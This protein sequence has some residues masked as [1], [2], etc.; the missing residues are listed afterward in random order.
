MLIRTDLR[1]RAGRPDGVGVSRPPRRSTA[2]DRGTCLVGLLVLVVTLA[3]PDPVAPWS[4]WL[5]VPAVVAAGRRPLVLPT[6]RSHSLVIGLDSTLLVLLGLTLPTRQALVV[7]AVAVL[8]GE[9]TTRRGLQT[10]LFNAGVCTL[11]GLVALAL[12]AV[13]PAAQRMH[14]LGLVVTVL[15]SA[16]Y[17]VVDYL[18]SGVSVAVAQRSTLRQ[19]LRTAGLPLALACFLGVNSLGFLAAVL[20]T[21]RPWTVGLLALPFASLQLSSHAWSQ[22]RQAEHRSAV[23]SAAAVALQQAVTAQEVEDL[24][25]QHASV[26][27]RV[28]SA[29]WRAAGP[30]DTGLLFDDGTAARVLVPAD[31]HT[32]TALTDTDRDRL[33]ILLGV[34]EQAHERLRLLAELRRTSRHD[35]LTGL[36]N[37]TVLHEALDAAFRT[38]DA[39]AVLFCD[40]DGFKQLNDTRGHAAGDALLVAVAGRLQQTVRADDLAVRLGGDE[41]AVLTRS[42]DPDDAV[43]QAQRLAERLCEALA[44]PYVLSDGPARVPASI[45]LCLRTDGDRPEDLLAGSDTAMYA[46]KHGGGA[47]VHVHDRLDPQRDVSPRWAAAG[48]VREVRRSPGRTQR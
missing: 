33:G 22:L 29:C 25:L 6:A 11:S 5:A 44:R 47:G 18:W 45:G 9:L 35:A 15:A 40:L 1:R 48:S 31:R 46:A 23:L 20:L 42:A 37:R 38:D 28:P 26:L 19:T 7:W 39:V 2:L 21:V 24:V 32:G 17:F 12:L 36:A 4:A 34:A 16:A 41:F 27:V 13:L 14:P 43:E 30:A 8:V 10:R 3:L